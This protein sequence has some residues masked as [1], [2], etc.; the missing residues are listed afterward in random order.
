MNHEGFWVCGTC[1]NPWPAWSEVIQAPDGATEP[2]GPSSNVKESP[3]GQVA[4]P[5]P[6]RSPPVLAPEM[7]ASDIPPMLR[8]KPPASLK[9][10]QQPQ[11]SGWRGHRGIAGAASIV[12]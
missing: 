11:G 4:P 2:K 7:R 5:M 12:G 6:T 8:R 3:G 10:S 1:G 9:Q